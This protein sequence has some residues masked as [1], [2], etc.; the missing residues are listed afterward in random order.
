MMTTTPEKR[1]ATVLRYKRKYPEKTKARYRREEAKRD[2]VKRTWKAYRANARY[3]GIEYSL[4]RKLH[5]DLVT[6]N[7]FYC[8]ELPKPVNGID[9]VDNS[10]GYVENNVVTA[11]FRCNS[12]KNSGTQADFIRWAKSVALHLEATGL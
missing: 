5:D 4:Q 3:K 10:V 7:C 11:C 12:S 8:G 2:P 9:R 1:R 6:D